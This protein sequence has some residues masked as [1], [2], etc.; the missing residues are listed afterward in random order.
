MKE[1]FKQLQIIFLS[2][3]LGQLAFAIVANYVMI[4]GAISDTGAFIYLVPAVMIVG[5]VGGFYIFNSNL[6]KVVASEFTFEKKFEEY[7]KNSLVRWAMM[8]MGNLLA[9]IAAI[10]EV[11]S[12]YFALLG[13]GMLI[14]STTRPN[15]VDFS[16]RFNLTLEEEQMLK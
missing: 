7:R 1:K 8:E 12:F 9:I 3:L 5:T 11:K 15:V 16:K 2:L 14:F 6:K 13:L 4:N 10:I